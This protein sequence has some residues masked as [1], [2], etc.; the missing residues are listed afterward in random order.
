MKATMKGMAVKFLKI[1]NRIVGIE[2]SPTPNFKEAFKLIFN[3]FEGPCRHTKNSLQMFD[4][5]ENLNAYVRQAEDK[6]IHF[7]FTGN[8]IKDCEMK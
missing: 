7:N 3:T 6:G 1:G 5:W 8:T 2:L 4:S